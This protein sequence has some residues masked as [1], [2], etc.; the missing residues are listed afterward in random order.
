MG[1]REIERDSS[2][3]S[4]ISPARNVKNKAIIAQYSADAG[5]LAEY[6]QS[7]ASGK[8]FDY[9]RSVLNPAQSVPE[10]KMIAYL[11]RI[12][13]GGHV[14]PFGCM[15][16]IEELTFR[17]IGYS[18]NCF[19]M[20]GLA[21]DRKF[22]SK[23]FVSLIGVDATKL[24]TPSSGAS[25]AKASTSRE[26][27][28]LNPIWVYTRTTQ[29]PFYAI[30]HRID[31]G[32]VI[33]LEP[34]RS[35][36]HALSLAGA[37]QSQKLAV[38]AIS[39]LQSLPGGDIGVLCDTVVEEVQ[40]LTGY[41][42]VMVYKFH[43]DDHGE[44]VSEIRRLDLEPYLGLHYPATDIPQAARFL[45]KQ[46]RVRM[47]C[48]CYA[49]P[50]KVIQSEELRQPLCLVNSTL[51]SPH[52]CHTQYMANMGSVA[53]LVMAVV[54]NGNDGTKLWGLLVCHHTSPRYVPFPLRYACEF[55]MQ[56]FG[57][58]LYME[59]Q[60]A[61]QMEEKRILRTQTLLCDMLL[62]DAP[63]GI[64]TQSP[65]IMDLVKCDGAALLYGGKCW[66]LGTTPIEAQVKD[67]AEWLLTNHGDSTGLS[68]DSLADAGYPGAASLGDA[69][70]GMAT[71][72]INSRDF[73]FWFRSH[74]AKEMK[75][76]GAKHHPEDK[77]D[78]GKMNPRFSFKAFLE[79]VK[80]KSLP[81]EV[82]EINAIH[83]LQL[84][85]RDSSQ[86]V[87]E[88]SSPKILT[89]VEQRATEM[90]GAE[91]N[92]L[93]SVAFEM[94]RLI[95]TATVPIFGVDSAGLVN[96]WNAKIAELTGLDSNEA[97]GKSLVNEVVVEESRET[98]QNIMT[99]ALQGEEDKN[100]E[101]KLRHFGLQQ[102][103]SVVYIV[104]NA[105][106]SRDYTNSVVGV[107][108]V[109][110]DITYEKY[111]MDKFIK[112]EGDY[113]AII[114][115]LNPLI[116]PIFASDENACC[117]EW[118][119]AMERITGWKRDEVL[120]KM[121]P[122]EIFGDLCR[123]TGQETLTKFMI[124]L[125]RGISGQDSEKFPF[126]FFNRKGELVE[127]YLTANKR[128][129]AGGNIIGCFCFLQIVSPDLHQPPSEEK[130]P[131]CKGKF[132]EFMELG[133][134]LQEMKNPLNGLRFTH[135]LL[136]N[137]AV[138]ENQK[139]FLDT[140]DA[141]ERQIMAIIEDTD[142][143]SIDE[144]TLQLKTEEFLLGNILDAIFSQVMILISGRNLQLIHEIPVEIKMLT[145]FGDQIR[146]QM[147]LSDFLL[148]VV[149][150]TTS[151][152]GWV[153]IK[154]S[155]GLKIIQDGNELIHL[156]FRMI[157]TGQGLPPEVLQDMFEEGNQWTTQEAITIAFVDIENSQ[158]KSPPSDAS[159]RIAQVILPFLLCSDNIAL[160]MSDLLH[161]VSPVT[162]FSLLGVRLETALFRRR[163]DLRLRDIFLF[164]V[165]V[166]KIVNSTQ[167]SLDNKY[168]IVD[169]L[170]HFSIR[171]TAGRLTQMPYVM[172]NSSKEKEADVA[173]LGLSVGSRP[174]TVDPP[175]GIVVLGVVGGIGL[176]GVVAVPITCNNDKCHFL[177]KE[178]ELQLL[179]RMATTN[180]LCL[181]LMAFLLGSVLVSVAV[182]PNTQLVVGVGVV[183]GTVG[184]GVVSGIV[185]VCPVVS[186]TSSNCVPNSDDV[187]IS[188]C[189][190][191]ISNLAV[192]RPGKET[193]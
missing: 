171:R 58:Q 142:L 1:S 96:G 42:R 159:F 19:E 114:Q 53:S 121:L 48:D 127:V 65:S 44:V 170:P 86:E 110:Q 74:T 180:D 2:S 59:M 88:N 32:I 126:G 30:M 20:L 84:I 137:T 33:D 93:S 140:S 145:L 109:G 14:Q 122:G 70:C 132:S 153:E 191:S 69:V 167:E 178:V 83:S 29:K 136:E 51:R 21:L 172:N 91:I 23:Q 115:S 156:Q 138:S 133:Y 130:M 181:M 177:W 78:G 56:A 16:A 54:V 15:L 160:K 125:Y 79:V 26:L 163:Q 81:W 52:G 116:P 107:C 7:G 71:A 75:W 63:L 179:P 105:C 9:S 5:I 38:R 164:A 90:E 112:L 139:Q 124:L 165:A 62:R 123:L 100:I 173:A 8:S 4:S 28:L 134:I 108:F 154:I 183:S 92:E 47:I 13:R 39:R 66:L 152:N 37:V 143:G 141:C 103:K 34:A 155:P 98:V 31:V 168:D 94:V 61:S 128:I 192:P 72:K 99:R 22:D 131:Q 67:I 95:E 10:E 157:H 36:D 57:L 169:S 147:V 73:L 49:K 185:G 111:V 97:I 118:N 148:N 106:T 182:P 11:S 40:K 166:G 187:E 6:E 102:Q 186:G 64:V 87:T 176:G 151:P 174:Y 55:L 175:P 60:L 50:V 135:K 189:S 120:E 76:G 101:L 149:S 18:E 184:V 89:P 144:G 113:K 27:S 190:S 41:D 12:Q 43:K 3:S 161:Y 45:F 150:H 24:F 25:L 68:T 129:D 46:N 82:S 188:W 77:D 17:I 119:A 146:L 162:C 80:S 104:A 158:S 85:M 117:S 35:T 193:K